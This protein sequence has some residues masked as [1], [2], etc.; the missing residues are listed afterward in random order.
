VVP[1]KL[2]YDSH[3]F[4]GVPAVVVELDVIIDDCEV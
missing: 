4:F 2:D 3:E 1:L